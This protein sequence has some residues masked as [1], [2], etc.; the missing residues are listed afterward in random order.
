KHKNIRLNIPGH[1]RR[2]L[3]GQ[4]PYAI[5]I[6]W[7]KEICNSMFKFLPTPRIIKAERSSK[8]IHIPEIVTSELAEFLGYYISEGYIRGRNTIV[9]TNSDERLLDRFLYLSKR[10]FLLD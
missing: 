10:L 9:F 7:A 8:G 1:V 4:A 2:N 3:A 5:K 6:K